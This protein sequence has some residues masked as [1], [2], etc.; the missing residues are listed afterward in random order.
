MKKGKKVNFLALGVA[1]TMALTSAPLSIPAQA[2]ESVKDKY[3]DEG[4]SLVW[5]DEFDGE[6]LNTSD[7]NVERHEPGWVNSELQRYTGLDEGNIEVKNGKLYI[8]PKVVESEEEEQKEEVE[9]KIT[10]VDFDFSVGDDKDSSDT[11]ALQV[12][13]GKIE[14]SEA[15][16]AAATVKLSNISLVDEE[17]GDELLKNTSFVDGDNW[18][19]GATSPAEGT[20][21]YTDGSAIL[22]ID[23]SGEEN[24]HIQLQ[25][26]GIKLESGH[27]YKFAMDATSSADRMVEVSL[28]DP[29]NGYSW[30]GG[31]KATI[32]KSEALSKGI[33]SKSREITSGRI[34]TQG[35][36]DFTYGRFEARAKVP[37]GKGYLPAFWLMASDEGLYGQWPK[38]GEIDIMEV[39]GQDTSKSYHTIHYGYSAGSGHKENQGTKV[40]A[41]KGY[42]D[43]YHLFRVDWEP[44]NITW[45]VDDEKVYST[46]DW[47]TGQD[48]ASQLTYPAPFD[49][50]FYIILNLA[51]G[52]SW[53]GYPDD[54]VYEHMNDDSY[55]VDYV[56]VY[57]KDA[58]EYE[59]EE[60]KAKRPEA[61]PVT[62]REPDEE[63]NYVI[64]G[65]FSKDI[66]FDGAED[67]S[68]D[69]WVLHLES[70]AKETTYKVDDNKI[71]IKPA[72][73]G[74]QN[75]SVQLKQAGIPMYKG[76]EYE[77]T[78]DA[79]ASDDR[80]IIIDVEG[81]DRG[82]MRYFADTKVNVGKKK[83]S[84]TY[85]FTMNE[86]TD[87][88]A[89]LEFNLGK[90]KSTAAVTISNVKLTHKSGEEVKDANEKTV[91]PD[92]N[93]IYNGGFD[94]GEGRLG[95]WI[96]SDSDAVTVTNKNNSRVLKVVAPKGTSKT[97]PIR[98]EQKELEPLAAGKYEF[99]FDGYADEKDGLIVN[100]AG[101]TVRPELNAK[102]SK[103]TYK[104][105][106]K[107]NLTRKE[108][109]V[110]FVFTK[111]G[112]YFIDN[113]FLTEA[114]LIKN[115]SF[116][117][118]LSG[119]SPYIHDSV[120]ANYVIDNMNGND[121]AFAI[122]ID[123]TVATDAGN[124][125]Y[126]QLNQDG[127]KLEKGKKYRVSFKAKSSIDRLIKY[128]LQEFEG[129]W[130]NYSGTGSVE[131]GKD[132][133]T[134]THDFVMENETDANTR[135]NITMGSVDGER[136]QK[137]HDVFIDGIDLVEL[138]DEA[139]TEVPV[140]SRDA[141]NK[142]GDNKQSE[143]KEEM[144]KPE[145]SESTPSKS[146]GT[147]GGQQ[148]SGNSGTSSNA[149]SSSASTSNNNSSAS[150]SNTSTVVQTSQLKPEVITAVDNDVPKANTTKNANNKSA[151]NT[152]EKKADAETNENEEV[153]TEIIEDEKA[154]TTAQN[155]AES[156]T[157]ENS[158]NEDNVSQENTSDEHTGFFG[159]IVNFFKSIIE[160]FKGLFS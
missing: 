45:Y 149:G 72:A 122:T 27:S 69:N 135:F 70:D 144:P 13:F 124:E 4:Y 26:N 54:S 102:K 90:Q 62:Y 137:K 82:W 94:Q 89:A 132:W 43:E 44:S 76:W 140:P 92:G 22:Q 117:A 98:V 104:F 68:R 159:T 119:F 51:V 63:G 147:T 73:E 95:Y 143:P 56:R 136:I 24:W 21:E 129:N 148:N 101:E 131:I 121:N 85:S 151:N 66:A 18:S 111:P 67:A 106:I 23:K 86:K 59:K 25:Q 120:N 107:E 146:E 58:S 1:T 47:Y 153:E 28:L 35:L 138:T 127:V 10:K 109:N 116:N 96:V 48:E 8:K 110:E 6:S 141:D 123:D 14:D 50:N 20:C 31:S 126:V 93:Y 91:R 128:S 55:A 150:E 134:F 40:I 156:V 133:K 99:S 125:W 39:M 142:A 88:N 16:T 71:K 41:D 130:T 77:L 12:N 61:A 32:E 154:P 49:Q 113:A 37:E 78:F 64:N 33:S 74:S 114:A 75:H 155:E 53:V 118:G 100:V 84:Y 11:I 80:D 7:W 83:Q 52:G 152:T 46:R 57:Q 145:A 139:E 65:D 2:S 42:S 60:K 79:V 108:T 19:Y 5:N 105:E 81:P 3:S 97:N 30:Y 115:G 158:E 103:H 15:G 157:E 38:C 36:H 9:E 17:T 87:P 160:F 29:E 112:E 34:T